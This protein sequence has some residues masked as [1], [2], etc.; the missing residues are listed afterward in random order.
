MAQIKI[1][2]HRNQRNLR[3]IKEYDVMKQLMIF[4][5]CVFL[6][7]GGCQGGASNKSGV[8]VVIE[9]GGEFPQSLAGAWENEKS[10]LNYWRI[11][12]EP[13]GTVSSAIVPLGEVEVRPNRTTKTKGPNGEPRIV[14]AG[15]F[16]ISYKPQSRELTLDIKIEHLYLDMGVY[17]I[18]KGSWEFFITGDISED[19]KTWESDIFNSPDVVALLPDPNS[20]KGKPKLKEVSKLQIGLGTEEEGERYIF[21]KVPDAN[22]GPH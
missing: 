15:D 20:P 22:A 10:D 7:I 11:V 19:G 12:F 9:G 16:Q 3:Q 4:L 5:I 18:L 17:G 21:T 1:N 6:V 13:D 2:Y 8:D 14:K